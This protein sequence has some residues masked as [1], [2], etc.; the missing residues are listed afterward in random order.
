MKNP[1]LKLQFPNFGFFIKICRF[2]TEIAD[3][4]SSLFMIPDSKLWSR[5]AIPDLYL[6]SFEYIYDELLRY[7]VCKDYTLTQ[8]RIS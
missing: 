7:I 4:N 3:S 2:F 6:S 5:I 8:C 1:Q